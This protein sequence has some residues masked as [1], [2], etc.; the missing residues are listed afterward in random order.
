[1]SILLDFGQIVKSD[2]YLRQLNLSVFYIFL[3]FS[4]LPLGDTLCFL[5]PAAWG[6]TVNDLCIFPS[7]CVPLI[8]FF[9]MVILVTGLPIFEVINT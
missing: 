5:T 4:L 7:G 6:V 2:L 3:V 9:F 1:M 8:P